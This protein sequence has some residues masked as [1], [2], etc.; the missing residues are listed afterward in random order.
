MEPTSMNNPSKNQSHLEAGD[1]K[2]EN[3]DQKSENGYQNPEIG[4]WKTENGIWKL[5]N[6]VWKLENGVWRAVS[7][8]GG[9]SLRSHAPEDR[10]DLAPTILID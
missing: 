9:A 4:D 2:P 7:G 5:E 3:G 8:H 1:W 6:G 10:E